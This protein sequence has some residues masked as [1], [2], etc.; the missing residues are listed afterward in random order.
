MPPLEYTQ[1]QDMLVSIVDTA[2]K[3]ANRT[4]L[5]DLD[6]AAMPVTIDGEDWFDTAVM[7]CSDVHAPE[8]VEMHEDSVAFGISM[9]L[10]KVHPTHTTLVRPVGRDEAKVITQ[11]LQS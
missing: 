6:D 7:Y 11:G 2:I 10:L 5:T 9:G 3:L 8:I 1:L 4:V